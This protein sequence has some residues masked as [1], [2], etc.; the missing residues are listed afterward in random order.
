MLLAIVASMIVLPSACGGGGGGGSSRSGG[1]G[2]GA[3]IEISGSDNSEAIRPSSQ[4]WLLRGSASIDSD[5]PDWCDG[6]NCD[7]DDGVS[8]TPLGHPCPTCYPG[9]SISWHN[10]SSGKSGDAQVWLQMGGCPLGGLAGCEVYTAWSSTICLVPGENR[11]EVE[12]YGPR[13]GKARDNITVNLGEVPDIQKPGR[14]TGLLLESV[15][16]RIRL[17]WQPN[18]SIEQLIGYNIYLAEADLIVSGDVDFTYLVLQGAW[19][20]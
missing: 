5:L 14:P 20:R 17:R 8:N 13:K 10:T 12:L 6:L 4:R 15:S 9:V 16:K 1:G 19:R 7:A 11:I 18:P 2:K 3:W